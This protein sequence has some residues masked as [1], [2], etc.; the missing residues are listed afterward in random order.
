MFIRL[1]YTTSVAFQLFSASDENSVAFTAPANQTRIWSF[2]YTTAD[3]RSI[4]VNGSL[5]NQ[6]ALASNLGSTTFLT[7]LTPAY[8]GTDGWNTGSE[9]YT[10]KMREILCYQGNMTQA[11]RQIIEGYLAWKWSVNANLPAQHPYYAAPPLSPMNPWAAVLDGS[12]IKGSSPYIS[13]GN[14]LTSTIIS[15]AG[16]TPLYQIGPIVTSASSKLLIVASMSMIASANCTIQMT[17]GRTTTSG[18]PYTGLTNVVSGVSGI[19]L[20]I[21]PTLPANFMAAT[22]ALTN[23]ASNL[24]GTVVDEPGAGTFYYTVYA[25]SVPSMVANST[26]TVNMN[27]LQM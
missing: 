25:S 3:A 22:L 21:A 20:P 5:V 24:N 8:I 9:S 18:S 2:T 19:P 26:L 23:V 15:D 12:R 13:S 14:L 27:V 7:G 1:N 4:F 17:V 16:G 11:N 6:L 10:G